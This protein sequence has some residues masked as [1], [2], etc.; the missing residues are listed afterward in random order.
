MKK[1]KLVILG[2]IEITIC[3]I[4]VIILLYSLITLII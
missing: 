3:A 2:W 1:D 4:I